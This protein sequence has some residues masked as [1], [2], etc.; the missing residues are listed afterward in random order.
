MTEFTIIRDTRE[1]L[2]YEFEDY[3]V[4]VKDEK[5]DTGD[6][7]MEGLEDFWSFERKTDEDFLNSISNDRDRFTNE[8]ERAKTFVKPMKIVVEAPWRDFKFFDGNTYS[9]KHSDIHPNAV[10]GTKQK[11]GNY[12][13]I[14]FEFVEG[15]PE[16]QELIY[17]NMKE[18]YDTI[19][20]MEEHI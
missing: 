13:N 15:R 7:A 14:D 3:P 12:Y 18:F 16:A 1:N 17:E 8:I 5:L 2:P 20:L 19:M 9:D 4:S 11:W 6:Y 10:K